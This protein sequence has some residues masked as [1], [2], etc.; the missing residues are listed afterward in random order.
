MNKGEYQILHRQSSDYD[1]TLL[2]D[3]GVESVTL[4]E[5]TFTSV[6][7]EALELLAYTA[8]KEINYYLRP[9]HLAQLRKILEDPEASGNDKYVALDLLKNANV[10]SG[11]VLPMCQDTGTA[12]VMGKKGRRVWTKG[13]DDLALAD[14]IRGGDLGGSLGTV[15][16]GDAILERL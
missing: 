12:I 11:G 6:S 4:G 14:G 15:A 8:Y 9:A 5:H 13:A 16:I 10:A 1:R 7:P 2:S 3:E